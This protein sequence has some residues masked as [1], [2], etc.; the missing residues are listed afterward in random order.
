[1]VSMARPFLADADFVAKAAAGRAAEIAPCI[2]C[3]QACLDHTFSGK[4]TSCLVNPRAC[5]E[6]E[7][8]Y[9]AARQR[10]SGSRWS[11][12]GRRGMMAP[13]VAA[14]RG[15]RVTL[16]DKAAG[17]GGQLNLARQVPGKEE[18]HGLVRLVRDD[19]GRGRDRACGWARRRR[20]T[21]CAALTRWSSPPGVTPARSGDSGQDGRECAQLHRRA[22]RGA[23]R[24]AGGHHRRGGH[25]V[26]RGR[27]S[28]ARGRQ[29][30]RATRRCGGANGGWATRPRQRGGLGRRRAATR[31]PGARGGAVAAQGGKAGARSGQDHRLDSPGRACR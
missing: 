13:I 18:F 25:R 19:G 20:S 23:G 26:R 8:V 30:D 16:F 2:A 9:D 28:G 11:A 15:H 12:R 14:E 22:E 6:T 29:P 31:A 21:T 4:L 24:A 5:H 3:N 7:L 27:V 17:L 10:R 1:M